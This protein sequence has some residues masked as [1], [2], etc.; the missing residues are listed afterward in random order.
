MSS[1]PRDGRPAKLHMVDP[2][3][4]LEEANRDYIVVSLLTHYSKIARLAGFY[5]LSIK[6]NERIYKIMES[7]NNSSIYHVTLY[8]HHVSSVLSYL[9]LAV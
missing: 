8:Q 1:I 7:G 2:E 4:E 6:L 5:R 9:T 3:I